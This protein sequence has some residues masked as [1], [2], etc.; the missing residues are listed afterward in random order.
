MSGVQEIAFTKVPHDHTYKHYYLNLKP[1]WHDIK[2][3]HIHQE[4]QLR[5][6]HGIA[7]RI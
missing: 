2:A 1:T 7:V 4:M 3:W 6:M 5:V